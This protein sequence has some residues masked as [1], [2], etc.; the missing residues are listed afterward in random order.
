MKCVW[1]LQDIGEGSPNRLQ[2]KGVEKWR[3][4]A[5]P[6]G[7][8]QPDGY[9]TR[10]RVCVC[11]CYFSLSHWLTS[12]SSLRHWSL[13]L[14]R[15][16]TGSI[17]SHNSAQ[18]VASAAATTP[19]TP[20]PL[21]LPSSVRIPST[22]RL[23]LSQLR[24]LTRCIRS[25]S[26]PCPFFIRHWG[27]RAVAAS[28]SLASPDSS[29]VSPVGCG[30]TFVHTHTHTHTD[31]LAVTFTFTDSHTDSGQA[32]ELFCTF[33]CFKYAFGFCSL[34]SHSRCLPLPLSL[35]R[36]LNFSSKINENK[37]TT[38]TTAATAT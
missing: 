23:Q 19:R 34:L 1:S 38:R 15:S 4:M 36:T 17:I 22:S 7:R 8:A 25:P 35:A 3:G 14:S 5:W 2:S 29:P 6:C 26:H 27:Q 24:L 9:A 16:A 32:H 12:S 10:A 31:S 11:V 33:F 18:Q 28:R 37:A 30:F 20:P 21:L 13:S